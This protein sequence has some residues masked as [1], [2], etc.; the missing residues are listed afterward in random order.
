MSLRCEGEIAVGD[1][2]W[3]AI[4]NEPGDGRPGPIREG[5]RARVRTAPHDCTH[6]DRPCPNK[7]G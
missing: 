2:A 3:H 6:P 4:R 1:V 5:S 7:V